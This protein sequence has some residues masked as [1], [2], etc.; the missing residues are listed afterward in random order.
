MRRILIF[1]IFKWM[2]I[3]RQSSV[4]TKKYI[5][6]FFSSKLPRSTQDGMRWL[7]KWRSCPNEAMSGRKSLRCGSKEGGMGHSQLPLHTGRPP[8]SP[9]HQPPAQ[10][11]SFVKLQKSTTQYIVLTFTDNMVQ[12]YER[13]LGGCKKD[14][15]FR[16]RFYVEYGAETNA[17][18]QSIAL[19]PSLHRALYPPGEQIKA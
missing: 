12:I 18:I 16:A 9:S 8:P 14:E 4:T 13:D 5:S 11:P 15:D 7:I 17:I 10:K 1:E 3:S 6:S 19:T 2:Q